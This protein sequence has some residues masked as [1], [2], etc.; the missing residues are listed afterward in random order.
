MNSRQMQMS[1]ELGLNGLVALGLGFQRAQ[2]LFAANGLGVFAALS[3]GPRTA[4]ELAGDLGYDERGL[5]PLLE[6]CVDLGLLQQVEGRYR[7]SKTASFFL[8]PGREGSFCEVLSFWQKFS[9]AT[10]GR[11]EDAVRSRSALDQAQDLFER[12][13]AERGQLQLFF[14]GLAGLAYWPAQRIVEQFDFG[15]HSHLLDVGGGSGA[16]SVAVAHKYPDLKIT[17]FDL[18]PVCALA[19]ERFASAGM[20]DR[21][22]AM[23]GDFFSDPLPE[24]FDCALVSNVLHDWSPEECQKLLSRIHD[25]LLP[26]GEIVIYELMKNGDAN[27]LE[28]DLF[29]LALLLDTDRGRPYGMSEISAWLSEAGFADVNRKTITDSTSLVTASRAASD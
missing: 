12:L 19:R 11:L 9:Y 5:V 25:S 24:G 21:L 7:N 26:G 14:D 8:V 16:F 10:W 29:A 18:E 3:K 15:R 4:D 2:V 23:A 1:S 27:A 22:S 20:D 17:L 6:A 13:V 28:V